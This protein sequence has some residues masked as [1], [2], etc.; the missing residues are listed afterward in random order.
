MAEVL[1]FQSHDPGKVTAGAVGLM[2]RFM[3]ELAFPWPSI[4]QSRR[5]R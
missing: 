3:G 1:V 4:G 5:C 2:S